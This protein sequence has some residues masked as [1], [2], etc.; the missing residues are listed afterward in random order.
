VTPVC[1]ELNNS[2]FVDFEHEIINIVKNKY[3]TYLIMFK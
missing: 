3:I 1:L 2:N